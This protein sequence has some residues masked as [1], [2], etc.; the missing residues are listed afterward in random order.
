[1]EK[2]NHPLSTPIKLGIILGLVYCI[3]IYCQNNFF[4]SNPLQFAST[5]LF[6]YLIILAGIFYTGFLAKKEMGGFITFQE[7]LKA[8]LLAIA[9]LEL[10]YLVFNTVY[11]KYI[12]PHFFEKLKA[13]WQLF[14]IK[15]NVPEDKMHDSLD[16][17]NEAHN[18]TAWG[19]I[20]SY[21]F[22]IIIDA[23]FAV[24]FAAALKKQRTVFEN[25][26]EQ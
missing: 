24:I 9:I 12:D 2:I 5:K 6:C 20:Q 3:L 23:V 15:N 7:C 13:S 19:L 11:V 14:F 21:G 22:S 10:F 1:M 4:Y 26:I 8:M 18:I 16:K 25:H 17:F